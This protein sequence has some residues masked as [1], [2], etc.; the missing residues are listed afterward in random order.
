M[1]ARLKLSVKLDGKSYQIGPWTVD[2]EL[3]ISE[4][5]GSKKNWQQRMSDLDLD[6]I[7]GGLWIAIKG[8]QEA[9]EAFK[10]EK[11]L[12]TVLPAQQEFLYLLYLKLGRLS[13]QRFP[14]FESYDMEALTEAHINEI[15]GVLRSQIE[16]FKAEQEKL[17]KKDVD[18]L[19]QE[20]PP[21]D[22]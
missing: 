22:Q 8:C 7:L 20:N 11:E 9:E 2:H 19:T 18:P 4:R 5:F 17:E 10:T 15:N 21:H 1:T 3:R 16:K 12:A 13:G 14:D 6:A